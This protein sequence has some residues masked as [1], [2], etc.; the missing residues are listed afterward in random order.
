MQAG[1]KVAFNTSMMYVKVVVT[2]GI[3]LYSTRL[4][5]SQLGESDFGVFNLIAGI[6]GMLAFFN[7]AV[8]VS[9]QRYMSQSIGMNDNERLVD[10]YKIAIK[11]SLLLG[12]LMFIGIEILGYFFFDKLNIATDRMFA[13]KIVFHFIALSTFFSVISIVYEAAIIAHEDMFLLSLSYILDTFLKLG[14]AIY[15]VYSPFDKLIVYG[16]LIALIC[17]SSTIIKRLFCRYKYDES[18][19]KTKKNL[20]KQLFFEIAKFSGWTSVYPL[21]GI[22]CIQGF[23]VILN[24]FGGTVVNAAYG[25][26]NQVNGQL[27]YFSATLLTA[28]E[29][30]IIKSE[31]SGNRERT[32]KL[33]QFACKIS[34]SLLSF[35]SIPL[36]IEM[37]Y[38]L[39]LWLENVP[40]NTVLFCRLIL[41]STLIS[42][43]T[44]GLQSGI[45]AVGKIKNYHIVLGVVKVLSVF[46]VFLFLK[47]GYPMYVVVVSLVAI[48]VINTVIRLMFSFKLLDINKKNHIL[49][50]LFK[51]IFSFIIVYVLLQF[52]L[53]F[54]QESF[55]RIVIITML[56]SSFLLI[57]FRFIVWDKYECQQIKKVLLSFYEKSIKNIHKLII[58]IK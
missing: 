55:L 45:Q 17:I 49:T 47:N 6:V 54:I 22:F 23:A 30:Q 9:I 12:I 48:E 2:I 46:F 53:H 25:I 52:P 50:M 18:K 41:V 19:I 56:S 38:V 7:A 35:F 24:M 27:A 15:L 33:S 36:I 57:V 1:T 20:D 5:L 34:F 29:P 11:L 28:I 8:C 10:V 21:T 51:L 14:V 31:G 58:K 13:S 40:E 37:P 42:Q 4:I 44:Y 32:I 16:I 39:N 3:T 43:L 26:A